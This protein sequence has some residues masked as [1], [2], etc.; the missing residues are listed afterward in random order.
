L[1]NETVT[2]GIK[3]NSTALKHFYG[4]DE[5]SF[6][7]ESCISFGLLHYMSEDFYTVKEVLGFNY[8][9]KILLNANSFIDIVK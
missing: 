9:L 2:K 5:P 7:T 6:I 8:V 1:A 4:S 3:V